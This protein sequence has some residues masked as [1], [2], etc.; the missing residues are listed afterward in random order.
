MHL[1]I[2]LLK[3]FKFFCN[4]IE[5]WLCRRRVC[6]MSL[7]VAMIR[8]FRTSF[9]V[10]T[11]CAFFFLF[12]VCSVIAAV[13][14]KLVLG[15]W[16]A[17]HFFL[18]HSMFYFCWFLIID[19][20]EQHYPLMSISFFKKKFDA[21]LHPDAI[22]DQTNIILLGSNSFYSQSDEEMKVVEFQLTIT[23]WRSKF[24]CTVMFFSWYQQS[25][26]IKVL[27]AYNGA[28]ECPIS[29]GRWWNL[30]KKKLMQDLFD[31]VPRKIPYLFLIW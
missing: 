2:L 18:R 12:F 17:F 16:S 31:E 8:S 15:L 6:G 24:L 20:E 14:N 13:K 9:A 26:N 4:V 5:Y 30:I 23:A 22:L 11:V 29:N 1:L 19:E 7:A 3:L 21:Y 10:K 27:C 28:L 25:T